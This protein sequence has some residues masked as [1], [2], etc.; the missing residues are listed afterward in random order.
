MSATLCFDQ[1][2]LLINIEG[3]HKILSFKS[4]LNIPLD[5]IIS[6]EKNP[7]ICKKWYKG[8]RFPGINL[9]KI[10]TA[11]T[12]YHDGEKVFWDV[13]NLENSIIINLKENSFSKLIIE[14]D[15]PDEAISK[16]KKQC[17][18]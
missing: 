3:I 18:L 11:G 4:H 9:P 7:E 8:I 16:I 12:F 14:V 1:A 13:T 10:I 5:Q 15:D 2:N 17:Q 6:V